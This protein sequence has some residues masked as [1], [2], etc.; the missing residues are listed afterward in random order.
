M[1]YMSDE[2]GCTYPCIGEQIRWSGT[3]SILVKV[4]FV[5]D[6][7]SSLHSDFE[8]KLSESISDS[9]AEGNYEVDGEPDLDCE[10]EEAGE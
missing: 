3:V 9:L 10:Y 2:D 4:D 6:D 7:P 5:A 1:P 8:E